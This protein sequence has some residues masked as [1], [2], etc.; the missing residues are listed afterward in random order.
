[1]N[2]IF[3]GHVR[4]DFETD[5]GMQAARNALRRAIKSGGRAG[6]IM[7]DETSGYM[8][9]RRDKLA[10]ITI[11]DMDKATRA[12]LYLTYEDPDRQWLEA[13]LIECSKEGNDVQLRS[14]AVTCMGHIGRMRGVVGARVV[15]ALEE[16][17][18][19]ENI[20]GI[21]EDALGDIRHFAR[22]E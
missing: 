7:S 12:L 20:G 16:F 10:D 1:M 14:L 11:R 6:V 22:V 3:H 13:L 8:E 21:A 4:S 17:L 5:P 15:S 9:T 2:E 18:S 19:D